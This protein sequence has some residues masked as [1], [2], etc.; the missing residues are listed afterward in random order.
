MIR[1]V[2]AKCQDV[3]YAPESSSMISHREEFF[4]LWKLAPEV[5]FSTLHC[6]TLQHNP[7]LNRN[8]DVAE[9]GSLALSLSVEKLSA[10][11]PQEAS[12]ERRWDSHSE[13]PSAKQHNNLN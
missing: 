8:C 2:L 10:K 5:G 11:L 6:N 7:A 12:Q 1:N 4:L 13:T 3:K 9:G